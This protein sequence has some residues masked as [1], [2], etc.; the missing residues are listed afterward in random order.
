M[1]DFMK[2]NRIALAIVAYLVILGGLLYWATNM[3]V[4]KIQDADDQIQIQ[5]LSE[6]SKATQ[7]SD[8]PKMQQQSDEIASGKDTL[9]SMLLDKNDA[10]SLIE[11]LETIA[12][13]SQVDVKISVQ[14]SADT[15]K[16][17]APVIGVPV[18][19]DTPATIE[20]S[21]PN[22]NYLKFT[23]AMTGSYSNMVNFMSKIENMPYYGDIISLDIQH[24]DKQQTQAPAISSTTLNPFVAGAP[25]KAPGAASQEPATQDDNTITGSIVVAFYLK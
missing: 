11:Q 23:L 17:A 2:K 18:N 19:T 13:Q 21:L 16:S 24:V 3:L 25:A 7:I 10:V 1:K 14:D 9:N 4:A 8:I 15:A 12:Q 22:K 5:Q 6:Q 20:D